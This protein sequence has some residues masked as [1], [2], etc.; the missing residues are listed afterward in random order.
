MPISVIAKRR[1]RAMFEPPEKVTGP[2]GPARG[3]E[4]IINSNPNHRYIATLYRECSRCSSRMVSATF[5]NVALHFGN[6][7][8]LA[9]R[10]DFFSVDQFR[11]C[12]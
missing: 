4:L 7:A 9:G 12:P 1:C 6:V 2:L 5:Y 11:P 8:P 3:W 10:A